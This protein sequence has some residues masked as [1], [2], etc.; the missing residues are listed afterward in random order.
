MYRFLVL[1]FLFTSC[2]DE[3]S[4]ADF[5]S[6]VDLKSDCTSVVEGNLEGRIT[7]DLHRCAFNFDSVILL[8]S[9]GGLVKEAMMI[10]D[11]VRWNDTHVKVLTD[12]HS[13][14]VIIAAT[15]SWRIMCKD[16]VMKVHSASN[17]EGTAAMLEYYSYDDR[18]DN[19]T[20][21]ALILSADY[22]TDYY[23]IFS[24]E[25]KALGLVDSVITCI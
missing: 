11:Q 9:S 16:A 13:S 22:P 5:A 8:T 18:I 2:N 17:E 1:V 23:P 6:S 4:L 19:T 12:C 25:A 14:C 7:E 3:S 15:A 10:A 24:T 21:A 20:L